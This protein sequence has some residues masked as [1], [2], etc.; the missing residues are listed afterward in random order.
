MVQLRLTQT[1]WMQPDDEI[2]A[3]AANDKALAVAQALVAADPVNTDYQQGLVA[4]Y[5]LGAEMRKASD[6]SAALEYYRR[7]A[8]ME[9]KLLKADPANAVAERNLKDGYI[10]I[11]HLLSHRRDASQA[12]LYYSKAVEHSEKL[13][14]NTAHAD[15]GV[16]LK[17][18]T[19]RAGAAGMRTRLGDIDFALDE[20]SR[21]TAQLPEIPDDP[22][23]VHFRSYRAEAY[24]YLGYAYRDIA[25][26]SKPP[27]SQTRQYINIA[28][29]MFRESMNIFD[30]IR[31]RGGLE[32]TDAV[33]AKSVAG[34]IAQCDTELSSS[35]P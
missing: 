33:E 12:L 25:A 30:D 26:A 21:L 24:E 10:E 7:T 4:A 13:S 16:S 20:C 22:T 27:A 18:L 1:L 19:A 2:A 35:P 28:R 11:A 23:N 3:K 17:A 14:A 15:P 31:T 6:P 5:A 8:E 29:D 34:E 9:E 32:P